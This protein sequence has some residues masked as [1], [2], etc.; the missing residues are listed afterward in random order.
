MKRFVAL[1]LIFLGCFLATPL[2]HAQ[3]AADIQAQIDKHNSQITALQAEIAQYQKQLNVL[4]T[5]KNTLQSTI[6]TLA[7][8]QKQL[9]AQIKLTQ[10]KIGAANLK[11][12]ELTSSIGD[13]EKIIA[14]TEA[15]IGKTLRD[16]SQNEAVPL[17]A[18][19]LSAG[20][21]SDAWMAVDEAVLLNRALQAHIRALETARIELT[22]NR[23]AVAKTKAELVAL[24]NS[25]STE[26]KSIELNKAAQ[27]KLLADTKNQ[28]SSYQKLLASKRAEE[29][30][31][32]AAL[33][34]LESQLKFIV[35]PS[36]IPPSGK[37]IL[38]WPLASVFVTQQFGQTSSS[39][40][41]YASGTHNGV[42][43]R[44][45]IGTPVYASLSGTVLDVNYGAVTNCQ[46]G[47]W[48]LI[49]HPNGLAT[50]YA[51]LSEITVQKGTN[52]T[53]GQ[54]IGYSGN[55][56]Y[57]TGPH[58]HMG[59]YLAEAVSFK[60]YTCKSGYTVTIP[61]APISAYLD[62]LAYL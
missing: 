27:Q 25:L 38:H 21:I 58:L 40:R 56:G 12:S 39:G 42:D 61:I 20:D 50:L 33:F 7:L 19:M 1:C 46:Y 28:E 15:T 6:S 53:T 17:L 22:D 44:A 35:D 54:V 2:A 9:D 30:A 4:G 3:T 14:N 52:V 49:K 51:H 57:A 43:F 23:D 11:I 8:Q 24:Q 62:P 16:T 13:K 59:L 37:G 5:Q 48:V 10:N 26:R 31:F 60:Q 34:Q 32:E 47:K 45:S 55:T 18:Q 36:H 29:A 41:L